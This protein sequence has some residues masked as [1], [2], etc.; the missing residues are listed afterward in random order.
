MPYFRMHATVLYCRY[1]LITKAVQDAYVLV[2]L[3]EVAVMQRAC[4]PTPPPGFLTECTSTDVKFSTSSSTAYGLFPDCYK[5]PGTTACKHPS[6]LL[7]DGK[8]STI[9][10]TGPMS[11]DNPYMQVCMHLV[12]PVDE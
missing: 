6:S 5:D 2:A 12:T 9:G 4:T 11:G 7:V 3:A 1:V 10:H 8:A